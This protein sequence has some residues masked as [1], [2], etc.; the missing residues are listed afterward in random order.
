M[1][2]NHA[3]RRKLYGVIDTNALLELFGV[4]SDPV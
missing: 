3:L 1:D 4:N 2:K